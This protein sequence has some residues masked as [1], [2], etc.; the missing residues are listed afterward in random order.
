M[1]MSLLKTTRSGTQKSWG[2]A[3]IL[4]RQGT[5]VLCTP[6]SPAMDV[7]GLVRITRATTSWRKLSEG[8]WASL[9][10]TVPPRLEW[11]S[12]ISALAS[13]HT[14]QSWQHSLPGTSPVL[15]SEWTH[16]SW[17]HRSA[18]LQ[19][20]PPTFSWL[21]STPYH[22]AT[23]MS[24]LCPISSSPPLTSTSLWAPATTDSFN[25]SPLWYRPMFRRIERVVGRTMSSLCVYRVVAVLRACSGVSILFCR[26]WCGTGWP[27]RSLRR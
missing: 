9:G 22:G 21:T 10:R 20:S 16:R 4:W 15:G 25:V 3:T 12:R 6:L 7:T 1:R 19:T 26:K 8:S 13:T 5:L 14:G 23:R 17:R 18:C 24:P 2:L 11:P 27:P